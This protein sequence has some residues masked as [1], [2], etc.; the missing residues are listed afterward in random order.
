MNRSCT[1]V[2]T[3]MRWSDLMYVPVSKGKV[4]LGNGRDSI[5]SVP[6]S[7]IFSFMLHNT[8]HLK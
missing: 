3:A 5:H 4:P 7:F 6:V 8:G 1:D 2:P